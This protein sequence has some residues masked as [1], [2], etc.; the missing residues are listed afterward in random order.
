MN[1]LLKRYLLKDP[2]VKKLYKQNKNADLWACVAAVM[3]NV[4]YESCLLCNRD[5]TPNPNGQALR[6]FAKRL[7]LYMYCPEGGFNRVVD[8]LLTDE[9]VSLIDAINREVI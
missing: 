2:E 3:F 5:N 7:V 8:L 6:T 1:F 4:P 9:L